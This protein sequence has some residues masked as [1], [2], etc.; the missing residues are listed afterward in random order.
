M[1]TCSRCGNPVEFRYVNGRCIPLHL[2]GGCIGSGN[3]S[4]NDYSGY[5]TSYDST[6]FCTNC[7]ECGE[8]VFFIRHNG[9]SVWIDPPL[10]PP[11]YKHGC[12]EQP[13]STPTVRPNLVSSYK[14]SDEFLLEDRELIVGI[15]KTTYVD[16][17]KTHTDITLE[18]GSSENLN[19]KVKNNAGFLLGRLC[20]YNE[21][22][23]VI[24]PLEEPGYK[25]EIYASPTLKATPKNSIKN[26]NNELIKCPECGVP[27]NPKN[28]NKHLRRQH[29][30]S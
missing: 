8:D 26:N 4:V 10:G 5:N 25:F 13:S 16:Y 2:Y 6:C 29:G 11:W 28:L 7:P 23:G 14:I 21:L 1:S 24:W 15:V 9:G 12:F 18:A 20:I 27:L 22:E 30:H 19:L 3:S 17:L